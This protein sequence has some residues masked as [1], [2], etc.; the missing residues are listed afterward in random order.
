MT[1]APGAG[2]QAASQVST[3]LAR[4]NPYASVVA[5]LVGPATS[6]LEKPDAAGAADLYVHGQVT[7]FNL[8]KIQ[9]SF[10]P[11]WN[12]RWPNVVLD[13]SV[14]L[15]VRLEDRDLQNHDPIGSFDLS[16]ADL[17]QAYAR[18][19]TI[20]VRVAEQTY[21]QVLFAGISVV[22]AR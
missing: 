21:K 1:C 4:T 17:Q 19:T 3:A 20:Q 13:P 18:Q 10:T 11:Q 16:Y 9:D 14:R 6:A 15:R 8:V 5:I 12:V 2:E 22:A 7:S